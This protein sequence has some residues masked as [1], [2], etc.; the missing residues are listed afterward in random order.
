MF[1]EVS[2]LTA[3]KVD[4]RVE[5][6]M[7]KLNCKSVILLCKLPSSRKNM[8]YFYLRRMF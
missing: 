5:K 2:V 7:A 4:A 3:D 6:A 1:A 8:D